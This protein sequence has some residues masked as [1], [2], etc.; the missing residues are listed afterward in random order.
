MTPP[1][2]RARGPVARTGIIAR[3][4]L[5]RRLA[6]GLVLLALGGALGCRGESAER[7]QALAEAPARELV[8][9]WE[10]TL[11][12]DRPLTLQT[13]PRTLPLRVVGLVAFLED[14]YG[15]YSPPELSDATH[16]GVYDIDVRSFGLQL[17]G[18]N[19]FPIAV[20][21]TFDVTTRS[22]ATSDEE[23]TAISIVLEPGNSRYALL[24]T[25]TFVADSIAGRWTA[26]QSLGGGGRFSMRRSARDVMQRRSTP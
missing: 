9:V 3:S 4:P 8:G 6:A 24:L 7:R 12:L 20:A 2:L 14:H 26:G 15:D 1:T 25:G 16:V 22:R 21:R 11:W 18:A 13:D 10:A 23:R 17:R 5:A 19:A